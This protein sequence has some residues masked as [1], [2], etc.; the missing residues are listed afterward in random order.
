M[1]TPLPGQEGFDKYDNSFSLE[2]VRK[3]C[4]EYGV[5]TKNLGIFKNKYYFDRTGKYLGTTFMSISIM[6]GAVGS[7]TRVMASQSLG[8]REDQR[9]DS[10]L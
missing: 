2:E 10:R 4:D 3:I 7:S 5:S 9:G 1:L 6:I 8:S